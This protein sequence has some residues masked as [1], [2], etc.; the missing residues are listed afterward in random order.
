MVLNQALNI[1]GVINYSCQNDTNLHT[2]SHSHMWP[3]PMTEGEA[4]KHIRHVRR[5]PFRQPGCHMTDSKSLLHYWAGA[6][7]PSAPTVSQWK[8]SPAVWCTINPLCHTV[9]VVKAKEMGYTSAAAVCYHGEILPAH[10]PGGKQQLHY[11][12]LGRIRERKVNQSLWSSGT[13]L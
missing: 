13:L 4:F 11:L 8:A 6:S 9:Q 12:K 10:S 1:Y 5:P 7:L 3:E 2:L